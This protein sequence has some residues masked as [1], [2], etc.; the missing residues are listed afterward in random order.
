[1]ELGFAMQS[2]LQAQKKDIIELLFATTYID[3]VKYISNLDD[4]VVLN[5]LLISIEKT[6]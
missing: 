4:Y 1:M 5:K 6:K 3:E 2:A